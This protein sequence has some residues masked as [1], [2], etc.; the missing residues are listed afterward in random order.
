M[1]LFGGNIFKASSPMLQILPQTIAII[2]GQDF[3]G[4]KY[5]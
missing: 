2:V 1:V 5:V 4:D 3:R